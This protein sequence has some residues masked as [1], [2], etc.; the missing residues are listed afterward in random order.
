MELNKII[1]GDALEVLKTFPD[2]CIDTCV[3]SPPY[4]GLRNYGEGTIKI[5]G[6]NPD[7]QHEWLNTP[8]R[9]RRH[10]EDVK[11]LNSKQA[12]NCG[13]NCE[14][15]TQNIC[16][17]CGAW[18]GQLGLEPTPE[19]YVEHLVE[20]FREVRRVLK[21]TGTLWLNMGDSYN[22]SGGA[23]G[24]YN[25]GGLKEGQPKYP[26]RCVSNLKPKDLVGIPWI[27]ALA[28]RTD[29]WYLR[30]DIIWVKPSPM[31]ESVKDRPTK[32]H[33]YIFLLSKSEKYFYDADAI[34][35][36]TG[37]E[38]DWKKYIQSF[39]SNKGADSDRLGKG[40][41]KHSVPLTHPL[42]RNKR[43]VWFIATEPFPEAHFATFPKALVEP[44]IKAGTSEK[45]NCPKC[46]APWERVVEKESKKSR[47]TRD[48]LI[49]VLPGRSKSS[50]MNSVDMKTLPKIFLGW[51]PTCSCGI[52]ETVPAVV[53]DP[54]MGSG[55][56]GL[57]AKSLDRNYIGIELN[58]KYVEMAERR[59]Y[60]DLFVGVKND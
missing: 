9:R 56:V 16:A 5:W 32:A 46:G 3:T 53:L 38:S 24:D 55:T 4:Y 27:V 41:R 59:I 50:R 29:G 14:L 49:G 51:H 6:G 13:A 47:K 36:R 12:T 7:C 17:K 25:K 11:N 34:R 31:P 58:P 1:C 22:G 15:P 8:P 33:E 28:L 20:I 39:G 45:G 18:R 42:G 57:V 54:F 43:S 2:E 52:E 21:K 60:G 44:C 37:N 10:P 19:M 26:G 30:Q 40:Y 48:Y 35:E 23:G